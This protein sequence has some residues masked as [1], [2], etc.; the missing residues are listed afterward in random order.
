MSQTIQIGD[1]CP[2]FSLPDSLGKD[3]QGL[4][5]LDYYKREANDPNEFS[6]QNMLLFLFKVGI[7]YSKKHEYIEIIKP[8]ERGQ[9]RTQVSTYK[10]K[11]IFPIEQFRI[12]KM[13]TELKQFK[14]LNKDI[15]I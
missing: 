12:E 7:L 11:I 14:D 9:S 5:Y 8:T 1:H 13:F 6:F 10:I 3:I 4:H 2:I 15:F